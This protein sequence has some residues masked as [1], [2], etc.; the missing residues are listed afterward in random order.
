MTSVNTQLPYEYYSLPF[1]SAEDATYTG[2]NLGEVL[3]GDRIQNTPYKIQV[4]KN[5]SC[6]VLC[7]RDYK[8]DEM[9][10]FMERVQQHYS[11]H[12]VM[13]NLPAGTLIK[14]PD[15]SQGYL[16]GFPLG[17]VGTGERGTTKDAAYI[18]NHVELRIKYH[19][20]EVINGE[21]R[22]RIVGF[23]LTPFSI[24]RTVMKALDKDADK[25]LP[26]CA[27]TDKNA[28]PQVVDGQ[29]GQL[30][31]TY[32]VQW[33]HSDIAW[34]S[35]WDLYLSSSDSKIHWFSVVNS[36]LIVLFLS[37]I[38]AMII[39]RTLRRDIAKYNDLESDDGVSEETGW[40]LLHGDVFRPPQRHLVL[41][42]ALGS[43]I[44]IGGM[45]LVVITL[46]M[47]G[48][49]SPASRG[50]FF[51][52][53]LAMFV[54]MGLIAGY[55]SAR[56][57]KT[58]KGKNWKKAAAATAAFYPTTVMGVLFVL[59]FFVWGK[60][61]SGATPF[62]AMVKLFFIWLAIFPLVF[63]GYYFGYRKQA[64][65]HPVRTNQIPRQVPEQPWYMKPWVSV[66]LAGTLPF[67]AVFIELYFIY[68]AIWL[69]QT[70]YLFGFL[71]IVFLILA[72]TCCEMTIVMIYFQLCAEDYHWWWR[73]FC[74]S[75]G[76]SV[77][78]F[79][80]SV[81]YFAT[82]L[83][84]TEFVSGLLYFSYTGLIVFTFWILTGTMGFYAT[85]FFL[86]KIYAE[87]RVD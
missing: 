77:Y 26:K 11:V 63:I 25:Q 29:A 58:C 81:Y 78:V 83:Q 76:A 85:Y 15:G 13:D 28:P 34:A 44:Q 69:D 45:C 49:L 19:E 14:N 56:M 30:V 39:V 53:S 72:I 62:T 16:D 60:N 6:L 42:A 1:C 87:V 59:N 80:Y 3:R 47:L 31:W 61:S 27:V 38:L 70:Y 74:I 32:S 43:G 82:R 10:M 55:Y 67:G 7:Q 65:E 20:G 40:K 12:W 73:S 75:G 4:L 86:R 22:Y 68:S 36:L 79:L 8:V 52:M 66:L 23:E 18:N 48:F 51:Q 21:Q 5:D 35:R 33:E 57:Y 50:S 64:Y 37:A 17:F 2:E 46:A 9:K 24:S 54:L 84:I 41:V 71:F